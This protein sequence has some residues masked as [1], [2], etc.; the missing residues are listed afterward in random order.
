MGIR[1][2]TSYESCLSAG[3]SLGPDSV[4]MTK[5]CELGAWPRKQ[6]WMMRS[7]EDAVSSVLAAAHPRLREISHYPR[8]TES[9]CESPGRIILHWFYK[10]TRAR[11]ACRVAPWRRASN[12]VSPHSLGRAPVQPDSS[13][14][15][16]T[17][18]IWNLNAPLQH[19]KSSGQNAKSARRANRA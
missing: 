4:S 18:Q 16:S 6:R 13:I 11:C 5:V 19:S 10:P 8:R 1:S 7:V 3:V 2:V 17:P 12:S 14:S 15:K 9:H